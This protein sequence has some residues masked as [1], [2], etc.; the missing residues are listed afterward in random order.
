[1]G[2]QELVDISKQRLI[3]VEFNEFNF[4][5]NNS[6]CGECGLGILQCHQLGAL[7]IELD[8]INNSRKR[9]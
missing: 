2:A 4:T 6:N 3:L 5:L 1:M 9:E 8:K 7:N